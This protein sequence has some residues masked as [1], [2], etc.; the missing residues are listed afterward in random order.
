MAERKINGG[1]KTALEMGPVVLFFAGFFLFRGKSFTIGGETYETFIIVTA[2]FVPLLLASMG[3]LWWLTGKLSRMQVL[4]AV[5]VVVFAG[6]SIWFND[7]RFFKMKPTAIYLIFAGILGFGLLRGKSYLAYVMDEVLPL[8]PEGWM[9]LTK[10][11]AL[12]FAG[13]ALANE[14]IWRSLSTGTWVSFKTIGLPILL[15]AFFAAQYRLLEHYGIHEDEPTAD[16]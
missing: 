5:L 11:F 13:L 14:V 12:F 16:D 1:L 8:E 15:F 10:R 9:I 4:T 3:I 6:L 2:I 7:E